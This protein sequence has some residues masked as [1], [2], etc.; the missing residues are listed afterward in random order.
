MHQFEFRLLYRPYNTRP[1][2]TLV[3]LLNKD[4]DNIVVGQRSVA[5]NKPM[6]TGTKVNSSC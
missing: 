4:C 3:S 6:Y 5:H 1:I 2:C